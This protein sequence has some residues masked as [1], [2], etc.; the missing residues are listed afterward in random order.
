[1]QNISYPLTRIL[2]PFDGSSSARLALELAA[3][4][5]QASGE[6]VKN[7]TLLR[8]V[9]GGYLARHIQNIDLRVIHMDQVKEWQRIRRN[10]LEREIFP[11]LAEG[12]EILRSFGV[13]I[14]IDRQIAEGKIGA[15]IVRV[16]AEQGFST[17]IMG[18][19][20]LSPI[21][22]LLLGSATHAVL[23]LAQG[24]TVFVLG[25]QLPPV[26]ECPI[27]P[28]LIPIDG[29]EPS[30]EAVRQ[31]AWLVQAFAARNPRLTLLHVVDWALLGTRISKETSPAELPALL[32]EEGNEILAAGRQILQEA[33]LAGL[34]REKL[35]P[36]NPPEAIAQEAE[37]GNY[38][39]ILMG[40]KGRS[41]LKTLLMGSVANGV[42][43]RVSRPTVA[44]VCR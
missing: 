14:P 29:S 12:E 4:L 15:E 18:R 3:R 43:H 23:A 41:A 13:K 33:G 5:A 1:M 44:L 34:W 9:G 17:I 35:L 42:L 25:Q 39:L 16:A 24:V 10:Y 2:I 31:A 27:S 8:V 20:G 6:A 22:E 30:L 7:L 26:S 28:L 40:K 32:A 38:A 21:K 11:L 36:G 19:R 37:S